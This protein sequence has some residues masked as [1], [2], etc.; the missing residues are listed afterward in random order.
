MPVGE[1]V[2]ALAEPAGERRHVAVADR[3]PHG[4]EA[5]AVDLQ[6]QHAGR[7]VVRGR[8][9]AAAGG[10]AEEDLVLVEPS[11]LDTSAATADI[12]TT[13]IT[14]VPRPAI[15]TP[16]MTNEMAS[17]PTPISRNE[18]MPSV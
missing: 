1:R 3:A 4:V 8:V 2:A 7:A 12:A 5:E 18:P 15:T 6:E 14:A 13:T 16:G 9:G 17:S 10:A 11:R